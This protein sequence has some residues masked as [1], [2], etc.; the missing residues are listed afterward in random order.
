MQNLD[1][2]NEKEGWRFYAIDLPFVLL[3]LVPMLFR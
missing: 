1:E 2:T 3:E